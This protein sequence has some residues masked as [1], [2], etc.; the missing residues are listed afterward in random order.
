MI[1][2]TDASRQG[3]GMHDSLPKRHFL[4]MEQI[5]LL[6]S[7]QALLLILSSLT[8]PKQ[9]LDAENPEIGHFLIL[10][11]QCGLAYMS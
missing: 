9:H 2:G 8:I 6:V 7:N 11:I 5:N 10:T 3:Y 4:S 1:L